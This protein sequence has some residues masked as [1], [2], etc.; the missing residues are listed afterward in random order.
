MT[1]S[2]HAVGVG[3]GVEAANPGQIT[4]QYNI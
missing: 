2:Q 4:S 3:Y 1:A